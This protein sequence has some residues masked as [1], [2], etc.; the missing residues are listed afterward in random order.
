V[1]HGDLGV[2]QPVDVVLAFAAVRVTGIAVIHV[3]VAVPALIPV[4]VALAGRRRAV[5]R[6]DIGEREDGLTVCLAGGGPQQ[7]HPARVRALQPLPGKSA[8]RVL[9][10]E[11]VDKPVRRI[12]YG[13][14]VIPW[15]RH[16]EVLAQEIRHFSGGSVIALR[17]ARDAVQE[18]VVG[19]R[20][21]VARLHRKNL[22]P[23]VGVEGHQRQRP[24]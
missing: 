11:E 8:G 3:V 14:A 18:Q 9:V 21:P 1:R 17:A 10:V 12:G 5:R 2:D 19:E 22:V 20:D 15:Y 13:S 4:A 7:A 16:A 6:P 24:R 23:A